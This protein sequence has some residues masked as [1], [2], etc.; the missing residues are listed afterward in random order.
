MEK[1]L[2]VLSLCILLGGGFVGF[3]ANRIANSLEYGEQQARRL[4]PAIFMFEQQFKLK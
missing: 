4:E 2:I 1:G 3:Q